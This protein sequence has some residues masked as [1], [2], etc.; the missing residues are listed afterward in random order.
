MG[1]APSREEA[2]AFQVVESVLGVRIALADAGGGD[3]T[4]DGRWESG[5]G[6][7]I[8][9]VTS[10]P[11]EA[12]MREFAK[13]VQR[14]ERYMESG[15]FPAHLGSLAEYLSE[16]VAVTLTGD[17]EKLNGVDAD[18][19]HLFLLWR[20]YPQSDHFSRLSD[21]YEGGETEP[22]SALTLPDG[23]TDVWFQGRA[24]RDPGGRD[25]F[26]LAVARFNR[27]TEWE[28]HTVRIDERILPGPTIVRDPMPDGW[29]Q[30]DRGD[31]P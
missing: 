21:V 18:E 27:H 12:E 1:Q 31:Q 30:I 20:T 29:R 17:V 4:P 23:I 11:S 15:T 28:R 6:T 3:K 16:L 5:N 14:G 24:R 8:I 26:E 25:G 10:P 7:A 13:S 22:V 19:R 2:I 9:E